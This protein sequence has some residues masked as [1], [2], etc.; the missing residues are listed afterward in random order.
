M[1]KKKEKKAQ[2]HLKIHYWHPLHGIQLFGNSFILNTH[3]WLLFRL[4]HSV[5]LKKISSNLSLLEYGSTKG[6]MKSWIVSYLASPPKT[7]CTRSK[8]KQTQK[9]AEKWK[10]KEGKKQSSMFIAD[11]VLFWGWS[12]ESPCSVRSYHEIRDKTQAS[13]KIWENLTFKDFRYHLKSSGC[14]WLE[15]MICSSSRSFLAL[16]S[17]DFTWKNV[18]PKT[19]WPRPWAAWPRLALLQV[20][21]QPGDLQRFIPVNSSR[22]LF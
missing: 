18:N 20:G 10:N 19:W 17:W 6:F 12:H 16:T 9:T 21:S 8:M 14:S 11:L 15:T 13:E 3:H 7:F 22:I 1:D 4:K 5:P 2:I